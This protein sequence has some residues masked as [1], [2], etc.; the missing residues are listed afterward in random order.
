MPI[1]GKF[2]HGLLRDVDGFP[3]RSASGLLCQTLLPADYF[4]VVSCSKVLGEL[5]PVGVSGAPS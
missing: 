5:V 2:P 3:G 4:G 1:F